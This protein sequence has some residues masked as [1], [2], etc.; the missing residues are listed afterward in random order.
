MAHLCSSPAEIQAANNNVPR[1]RQVLGFDADTLAGYFQKAASETTVPLVRDTA[2]TFSISSKENQSIISTAQGQLSFLTEPALIDFLSRSDF[3][4]ADL[5]RQPTTIYCML[6]DALMN[7]YYRFVRVL[8]QACFNTLSSSPPSERAPVLM[9]LDEQA[10]LGGMEIIKSSAATLRG[11]NVRI[12]SVFQDLNQL[13]SL[14]PDAWETFLANAGIIQVMGVN[15]SVTAEY[16]SKKIGN[17]GDMVP[18]QSTSSNYGESQAGK[19]YGGG[20]SSSSSMQSVPF[21]TAQALYEMPRNRCL[22]FLQGLAY[23]IVGERLGYHQTHDEY[24]FPNVFQ[25]WD[26]PAGWAHY[27]PN[28]EYQ[29]EILA[30]ERVRHRQ[31]AR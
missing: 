6:P 24:D 21:M 20:S 2:G 23:P 28:A 13:K 9:L 15:D 26:S 12:W 19:S 7:T 31:A 3:D 1:V 22:S 18:S 27:T 14:Y 16:F 8:V 5:R 10:K 17:T 29:P 11:R 4:F 30:S 25:P